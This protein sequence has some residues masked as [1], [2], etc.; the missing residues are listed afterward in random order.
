MYNKKVSPNQIRV[1]RKTLLGNHTAGGYLKY[2]I[3][4]E[5]FY[6]SDTKTI[7]HNIYTC[8]ETQMGPIPTGF[9]GVLSKLLK[10]YVKAH[11][12]LLTKTNNDL[13][14]I[15]NNKNRTIDKLRN[16]PIRPYHTEKTI[17]RDL[18]V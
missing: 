10:E 18:I 1:H 11:H 15:I 3:L 2:E 12:T 8:I 5:S 7:R 9:K 13:F 6:M 17:V 4:T 14:I 16:N